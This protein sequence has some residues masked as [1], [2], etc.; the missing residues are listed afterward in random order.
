[1]Y[2]EYY[3]LKEEP[4]RLTPDPR[5][6]HMTDA[7]RAALNSLLYGVTMRRGI[8]VVTGPVGCGKTTLLHTLLELLA[9]RRVAKGD[10][11]SA[12]IVNPTLTRDE[13]F[14]LLLDEFEISCPSP[15]KPQR[16]L[17][18]EKMFRTVDARGGTCILF[19]DEAH[20][21]STE[22]LEE[23]RLLTNIDTHNGKLLQVILSGQ[24]ELFELLDRPETRALRQRIA[25]RCQIPALS[26]P[27]TRVYIA[28]RLRAAGLSGPDLFS[29]A[30]VEMVHRYA[31]GM[32]RL[33]NLICDGCLSMGFQA[34]RSTIDADLV[35]EA[36]VAL[37]LHEAQI[38][39]P[40]VSQHLLSPLVPES[41][42]TLGSTVDTLIQAMKNGMNEARSHSQLAVREQR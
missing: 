3:R 8:A 29:V 25:T 4:F 11:A 23:I 38:V 16:L 40:L 7:Y 9:Q 20:L 39:E 15:S 31:Q 34:Q 17:A 12:L 32:P 27:D 13:F 2:T 19:V 28:E 37:D 24:V 30:A 1:M 22:L 6:L 21:L 26:L 14:E 36:A 33:I 5:F 42:R 18:L 41:G 35:R 10:C